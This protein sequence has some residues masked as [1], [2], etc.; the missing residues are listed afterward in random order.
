MITSILNSYA[1]NTALLNLENTDSNLNTVQNQISTGL[2]V[3]SAADNASYFS[4]A[5]VL[6][7][8]SSALTTVGDTLN[9]GNSSLSVA[10]NA[11]D[12][13]QTTLSDIKQQLVNASVPGAEWR[14]TRMAGASA[15]ID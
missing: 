10:A 2:S 15:G 12:Q 5:S 9:E 14:V 3:S 4:I 1:A 8:D 11:L 7:S 6:R 13:I